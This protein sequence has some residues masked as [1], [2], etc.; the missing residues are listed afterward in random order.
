MC[1]L[2]YIQPDLAFKRELSRLSGSQL[3]QCMQCGNCSAVCSLAPADRPFPRKEMVWSAWGLKDKLLGNV[4]IWL[5]H[6]CGDCSSYCPRDVKPA[7]VISAIR[8]KTYQHYARPAFLGKLVSDPIWLPV[9]LA[10]PVVVIIAILSLAGTF[11]IPEGHVDYSAFFPHGLLNATFSAIT[12]IFYLIA[13]FGIGRF[14]RDM[15]QQF[16]SV[17]SGKKRVPLFRVLG[18]ILTHSNFSECGLRKGGKAAHMLLFFGFFLLIVVTLYA[19]WATL[20][21]HYPLPITNPFKLLGNLASVMIY[22]GL[23]IMIWQRLF[24]RKVF[25]KSGYSDWLLLTAIGLLTLSGTLVQLARLGDWTIA[26]HLYF[27]HLVAIWFVIMYLPFTKLGH[28]FY[29]TAALLY[30]RSIGRK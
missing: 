12:L 14:W 21:H 8:L 15:K 10:I 23:A 28:I 2:S 19:I 27:F 4:D 1:E 3:N 16:P 24:N 20:S 22:T 25:G 18:E 17:E 11:R 30:A 26:Y 7:D 6:Q 5:C 29:R 13:S 9:A